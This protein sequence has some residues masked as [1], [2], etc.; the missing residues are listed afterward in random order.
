MMSLAKKV[1]IDYKR[2]TLSRFPYLYHPE[3]VLRSEIA[4]NGRTVC[5]K[6]AN[7]RHINVIIAQSAADGSRHVMISWP[8]AENP[9]IEEMTQDR[10]DGICVSAEILGQFACENSNETEPHFLLRVFC[11]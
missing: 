8:T 9:R 6:Y 3:K 1:W 7:G 5:S 11:C 2:V 4:S 10:N